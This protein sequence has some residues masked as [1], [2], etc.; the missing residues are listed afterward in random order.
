MIAAIIPCNVDS[1]SPNL[2]YSCHE[3]YWKLER[4]YNADFWRALGIEDPRSTKESHQLC[5]YQPVETRRQTWS[6]RRWVPTPSHGVT[7]T[8]LTLNPKKKTNSAGRF[9]FPTALLIG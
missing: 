7:T 2:V 4:L 9:V 1:C 6:V 3:C 8:G 5:T